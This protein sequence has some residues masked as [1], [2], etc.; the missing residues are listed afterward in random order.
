MVSFSHVDSGASELIPLLQTSTRRA[1][2][3]FVFQLTSWGRSIGSGRGI[4]DIDVLGPNLETNYGKF[5]N[6][7]RA[8]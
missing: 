3:A 8:I 6:L 2:A 5:N 7:F 1:Q 4:K